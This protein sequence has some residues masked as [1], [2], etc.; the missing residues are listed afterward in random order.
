MATSFAALQAMASDQQEDPRTPIRLRQT[1]AERP[2]EGTP[3][4]HSVLRRHTAVSSPFTGEQH[5]K[6][7]ISKSRAKRLIEAE[8]REN[9][10]HLQAQLVEE[11][12]RLARMRERA[13]E[14]QLR[15]ESLSGEVVQAR[16]RI[17]DLTQ[18]KEALEAHLRESQ[19]RAQA[20][21]GEKEALEGRIRAIQ[22][23]SEA[24][25]SALR[26]QSEVLAVQI[27]QLRETLDQETEAH[28]RAQERLDTEKE[29]LRLATERGEQTAEELE[30]QSRILSRKEAELAGQKESYA[31]QQQ[32]LL[33]KQDALGKAQEDLDAVKESRLRN[34]ERLQKEASDKEIAYLRSELEKNRLQQ[35]LEAK[36]RTIQEM[37]V[38]LERKAS[39]VARASTSTH[40]E[41][42]TA[43]VDEVEKDL[44]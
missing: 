10:A 1:F 6:A 17:S 31:V 43:G 41:G 14:N 26:E 5:A 16:V 29:A 36:E 12:E 42:Q 2:L 23:E 24:E 33:E 15:S 22:A 9:A 28:E 30:R 20:L 3:N 34:V 7:E 13:E 8:A 11:E 21:N 19:E 18:E 25:A 27:S 39:E 37:E 44:F 40:L 4:Y 32:L 35:V 38:I